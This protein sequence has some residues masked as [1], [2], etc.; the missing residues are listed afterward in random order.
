[1][2]RV[3][4]GH[5]EGLEPHS[6]DWEGIIQQCSDFREC[7]GK[8]GDVV[9]L[10]P[11]TMHRGSQNLKKIPRFMCNIVTSMAEPMNFNRPDGNYNAMELVIL[12]ALGV[13][14]ID[15]QITGQRQHI[16]PHT[17]T[18]KTINK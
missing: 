17:N 18:V 13:D 7:T 10:H 1:V 15:F 8:A 12:H 4:Q 9:L 16:P 2:A 6:F 11:F 3:L 5:P 14:S